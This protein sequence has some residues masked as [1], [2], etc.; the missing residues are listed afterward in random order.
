MGEHKRNPNANGPGPIVHQTRGVGMKSAHETLPAGCDQWEYIILAID[1]PALIDVLN[2]LGGWG[3]EAWS[4]QQ[5]RDPATGQPIGKQVVSF[6]RK[7]SR[8]VT[9]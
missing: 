8:L 7:K 2:T 1:G 6:K 4:T 3:W 9:V 5:Q